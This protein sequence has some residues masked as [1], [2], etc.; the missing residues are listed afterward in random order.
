MGV[1]FVRCSILIPNEQKC[2]GKSKL[3]SD[4]SA[5]IKVPKVTVPPPSQGTI[6]VQSKATTLAAS[7]NISSSSK[8]NK[9]KRVSHGQPAAAVMK[10]GNPK[11]QQNKKRTKTSTHQSERATVMPANN[12]GNNSRSPYAFE[13]SKRLTPAWELDVSY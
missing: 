7:S 3:S 8:D 1:D 10:A 11:K 4:G 2:I 9:T 6:K 12:L 13:S 5:A